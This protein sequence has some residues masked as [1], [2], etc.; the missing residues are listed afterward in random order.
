ML[1]ESRH[2]LFSSHKDAKE[3]NKK[4]ATNYMKVL[5]VED[6]S[7][8]AYQ[9]RIIL[10]AQNYTVSAICAS[11]EE[12]VTHSLQH[13]PDVI[14]MDYNLKGSLTGLDAGRII[15]SEV[16]TTIPIIFITAFSELISDK[17]KDSIENSW[18][19]DKP[20]SPGALISLLK[21]LNTARVSTAL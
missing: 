13:L 20:V 7:L 18:F 15:R 17:D 4:V 8:I 1:T 14:L 2:Y 9:Y 10:K 3:Q 5:I 16:E 21:E 12:A 6:E 11:G 19:L